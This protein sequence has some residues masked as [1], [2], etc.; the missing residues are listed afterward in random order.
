MTTAGIPYPD[1]S[2][3]NAKYTLLLGLMCLL[4]AVS[5]DIYL[6]SLPTVVKDLHTTT[7][8]VQLTM[9]GVLLGT[10]VG[11][12]V[13]GPMSDWLGRRKP[14][15]V[16][17][18][19]HVIISV[20]CAAA[21]GI[22]M[23]IGLR[24]VQGF[25]NASATVVAMAVV[26][27]K[28][29][30]AEASRQLSRLML[31][32]GV[33][34]LFAPTAGGLI[35]GLAGWRSGFLAI[36]VF[37]VGLW[38]VVWRRLPETLPLELRRERGWRTAMSGYAKLLRDPHFTAVAVIPGLVQAV[39]ISYVVGSPFVLQEGFG[40]SMN[41]FALVFAS[42]GIALVTGAQVNAAVVRR[43]APLHILRIALPLMLTA[44][45]VLLVIAVT[46][47]GGLLGMVGGLWAILSCFHFMPPNASAIALT[48][49]RAMAG[50]AAAF[51]GAMQSG[52]AGVVSPLVGV[53]G[54]DARAM[55]IVMVGSTATALVV[56]ATRTSA[57]R[58]TRGGG[59]ITT[60]KSAAWP[61]WT[62]LR[63]TQRRGR[64]TL[65]ALNQD[66]RWL[67]IPW[68]PSP[69]VPHDEEEPE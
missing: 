45:V 4:P 36:A 28:F 3:P 27:D 32:I 44:T 8:A 1:G 10:A 50:T 2:R 60:S 38:L 34:P 6:P 39:L 69:A 17:V 31:V 57:Y 59:G 37:G 19:M 62:A 15:L 66:G 67:P 24:V 58:R 20:L 29:S 56:L 7:T 25:F 18:A 22:G 33:A 68:V 35:A 30:G 61:R 12:L 26:R 23:L 49:Y 46:G 16:G 11:Q 48:P 13:M 51:I 64:S 63:V 5:T 42:G 65:D 55:G 41:Q 9:T 53:L 21:P 52:V 43:V 14:V 40:L 54:G 47:F